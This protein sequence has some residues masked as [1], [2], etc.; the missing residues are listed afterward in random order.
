VLASDGVKSDTKTL[1]IEIFRPVTIS[2]SAFPPLIVGKQFTAQ[3]NVGGGAGTVSFALTG[4]SLPPGLKLDPSTGV[5]D[6]VPTRA[7]AFTAQI[8]VQTS[9]GSTANSPLRL[10]VKHAVGFVTRTL[11]RAKVGRRYSARILLQGGVDPIALSSTSTFPPGIQ[12]DADTGILSGVA[13][14]R[15]VYRLTVVANDSY[16]GI[17]VRRFT[18]VVAG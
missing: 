16:G 10:V 1:T 17:A 9:F 2:A 8:G 6:G 14:F 15:G 7:G 4:G 5:L 18:I 13:R 3:L 11:P 12:L